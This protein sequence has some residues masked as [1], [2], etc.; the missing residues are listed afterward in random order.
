MGVRL[1]AM[2]AQGARPQPSEPRAQTP[3]PAQARLLGGAS[4]Q[5]DCGTGAD[6]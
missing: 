3:K 6:Y 4:A 2:G 1:C 5:G